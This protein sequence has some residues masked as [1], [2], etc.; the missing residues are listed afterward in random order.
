LEGQQGDTILRPTLLEENFMTLATGLLQWHWWHPVLYTLALTHIS[1]IAVTV[2]LHRHSAHRALQLHPGVKHFFRFWLW[3]TTS[4]KTK[5]WTA[6]H[7]RHHATCETEQDPHSPQVLGIRKVMLEGSELYKKAANEATLSR[8]GNGTPDD[9]LERNVYSHPLGNYAGITAMGVI[10]IALFGP[11][12]VTIWAVQMLWIPIWAAGVIN[13]LAHYWGYRNFESPDAAR[14]LVPIAA[15]I[16]GEELHNNH[17]TYPNSAKLSSRWYEFDIGW[18]YIRTLQLM[19]LATEIRQGPVV[20]RETSKCLID[21]DTAV[22]AANDRFRIMAQFKKQ[23]LQRTI[24]NDRMVKITAGA[25]YRRLT[26]WLS[27]NQE[28]WDDARHEWMQHFFEKHPELRTLHTL[29][30]ELNQIWSLRTRSRDELVT[31]FKAW[32]E[33]A[34][35]AGVDAL[36]EFSAMLRQYTLKPASIGAP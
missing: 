12:G 15:F 6:I 8:F 23:V 28:H 26:A 21:A 9:W 36:T 5:E 3:L 30:E 17:H 35:A 10:N 27:E 34:D 24:R 33:K 19:G 29:K 32:C 1:I 4:I 20:H 22:A 14:N 7:R 13:G 31:A 18:L 25:H 16:G 11:I 2:Y